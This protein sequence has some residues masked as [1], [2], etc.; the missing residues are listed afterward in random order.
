MAECG[1]EDAGWNRTRGRRA[2]AGKKTELLLF[3]AQCLRWQQAL[4]PEP[5]LFSDEQLRAWMDEDQEAM[6]CFRAG[7]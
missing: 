5:G 7:N 6:R 1:H 4:L 3:V 2:A